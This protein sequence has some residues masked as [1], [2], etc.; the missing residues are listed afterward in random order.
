MVN[1]KKW[2]VSDEVAKEITYGD[3]MVKRPLPST[4][5]GI[6]MKVRT[7]SLMPKYS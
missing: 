5:Q 2:I 4:K 6:R 7:L 1:I 3:R